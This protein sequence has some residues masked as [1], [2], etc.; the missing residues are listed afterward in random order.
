MTEVTEWIAL[1]LCIVLLARAVPALVAANGTRP[2]IIQSILFAL[3]LTWR[4]FEDVGFIAAG[5]WSLP[6]R[7][8]L[9]PAVLIVTFEWAARRHR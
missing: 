8:V 6:L 2:F 7:R 4:A 1:G 5:D 9:F 3:F